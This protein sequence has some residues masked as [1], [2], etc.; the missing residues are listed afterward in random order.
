MAQSGN[1]PCEFLLGRTLQ[2]LNH[3]LEGGRL[4]KRLFE[5]GSSVG[6]LCLESSPHPALGMHRDRG[7]KVGD[8]GAAGAF[9]AHVLEVG[10][11][12]LSWT[13]VDLTPLCQHKD[14]V[15]MVVDAVAS[16]VEC[17][18]DGLLVLVC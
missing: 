3:V 13:V 6:D 2:F 17:G 14:F 11:C 4:A 10:A 8:V 1:L 9:E 16:L 18:N 5:L 15:E 12:A 7:E